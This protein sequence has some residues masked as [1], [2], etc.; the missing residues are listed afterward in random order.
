MNEHSNE[1]KSIC[2]EFWKYIDTKPGDN[3]ELSMAHIHLLKNQDHNLLIE[4][5]SAD[6]M[7]IR[8]GE[9]EILVINRTNQSLTYMGKK[10]FVSGRQLKIIDLLLERI[11]LSRDM[12]YMADPNH[13]WEPTTVMLKYD[14]LHSLCFPDEQVP[15]K[16][17]NIF[18][19]SPELWNSLIKSPKRGYYALNIPY[20]HPTKSFNE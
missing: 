1:T 2:E 12:N 9:E 13:Q 20:W 16:M 10:F 5:E 19:S 7:Y 3:P 11:F 17:S 8:L 4:N 6:A 15:Q 14:E 18:K